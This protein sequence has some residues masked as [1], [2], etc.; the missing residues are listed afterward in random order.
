MYTS[1]NSIKPPTNI[2][3][4]LALKLPEIVGNII[5]YLTPSEEDK[6]KPWKDIYQ[7]LLVNSLWHDC[8]FRCLWRSVSFE[9]SALGLEA[10]QKFVSVVANAPIE[11]TFHMQEEYAQWMTLF[12]N[13][14]ST[15]CTS[16]ENVGSCAKRVHVDS[17]YSHHDQYRNAIRSL[18]LWKVKESSI[19]RSLQQI[20]PFLT[21]AEKLEFY[22][23]DNLLDKSLQ[24]LV[25]NQNLCNLTYL[26][27]AGCCHLTDESMLDTARNCPKL[28]HLDLRA[29]GKISDLS[30]KAVARLCPELHHLN[31]GRVRDREKITI[32]SI[33]LVAKYTQISVLGLAGCD[34]TD[35]CLLLLAKYRGNALER[36]SV[37]DCY[38]LTNKSVHVYAHY[39]PNL[40]VFEMKECHWIDDWESITYMVER[41][42]LLTLCEQQSKACSEWAA[43]RGK[44]IQIKAPVK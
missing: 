38:R 23:C 4:H 25:Q 2:V 31:V 3:T 21:R 1:Y 33:G 15:P 32:Q 18:S 36:I 42:V 7:C 8:A 24:C 12:S 30:I 44:S 22:I 37:N 17:I 34:I 28:K 20:A 6:K 13:K 43:Q 39:C 16:L 10:F 41:H 14:Y 27:L 19:N 29:C 11:K 9:E 40:S 26:S 35:D 5:Q